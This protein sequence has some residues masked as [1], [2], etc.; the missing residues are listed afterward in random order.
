MK[1]IRINSCIILLIV[2][3]GFSLAFFVSF[4]EKHTQLSMAIGSLNSLGSS[5]DIYKRYYD[6]ISEN[7]KQEF[8]KKYVKPMPE[9]LLC[10]S[11][12]LFRSVK[13]ELG[14]FYSGLSLFTEEL[15]KED[16]KNDADCDNELIDYLFQK[17]E[18]TERG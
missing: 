15:N 6:L 7:E 2:V 8:L 14:L 12:D 16:Y 1:A 11:Q 13:D 5:F 3:F 4:W 10:S 18:R 17:L 9:A